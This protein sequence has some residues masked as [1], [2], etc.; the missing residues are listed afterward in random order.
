[1]FTCSETL[2][3]QSLSKENKDIKVQGYVEA[4]ELYETFSSR[5]SSLAGSLYGRSVT[6]QNLKH[7]LH[8]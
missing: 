1:M 8:S 2:C 7:L 6:E 5:I 4:K 3:V